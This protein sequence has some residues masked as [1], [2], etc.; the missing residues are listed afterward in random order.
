MEMSKKTILLVD[1]ELSIKKVVEQALVKE[2]FHVLYAGDGHAGWEMFQQE[3][4]DLVILDIML[5]EKDGFDVLRLIREQAQTPVMMLSAKTEIIDKSVGFNLGADDY[6]TKP[7][8]TVELVLRVKALL[9]RSASPNGE[10]NTAEKVQHAE[11][12][13][14]SKRREVIVRGE[15]VDLTAKEFDLLSFLASH[16]EHVFT[17]EQLFKELWNEDYVAD[18]GSISVFVRRI[19]TKIEEDPSK[20]R[21]LKT[22][23]GVGYKFSP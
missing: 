21:F 11:I 4:P 1:D 5:P 9:R 13:I 10:I 18:L 7:F 20:P 6:L 22:V 23:W 12:T 15:K 19:R 3:K 16:P 14:D 17:R 8:S 2:G